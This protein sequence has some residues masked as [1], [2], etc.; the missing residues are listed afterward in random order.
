LNE[1]DAP[2]PSS[3]AKRRDTRTRVNSARS[4]VSC[5]VRRDR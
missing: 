3:R 1:S 2:V 5:G 4:S